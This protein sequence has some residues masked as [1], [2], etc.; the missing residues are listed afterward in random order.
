M[1]TATLASLV[2]LSSPLPTLQDPPHL[3]PDLGELHKKVSTDNPMA[4]KYFDQG[5]A[6]LYGFNMDEARKNFEYATTLDPDCAMIWWGVAQGY[7]PH[8]NAMVVPPESAMASWEAI[9]KAKSLNPTGWER[10][11]I[12]A[13]EKRFHSSYLEDRSPLDK[14]YSAEMKKVAQKYPKDPDL[15][16]LYA[17]SLMVQHPWNLHFSGGKAKPWTDDIIQVVEDTLALDEDHPLS[18]HLYIHAVEGSTTPGRATKAADTLLNLQ[19]DLGHM[20]HM[21]SHIYVRTGRWADA[22]TSNQMA[23][24]AEAEY[25][26]KSPQQAGYV[27]YMMHNHSMLAYAAM[28]S[29]RSELAMDEFQNAANYLTPEMR[30]SFGAFGDG[31]GAVQ[32]ETYVRFGL[33]DEILELPTPEDDF[34]ID[35]TIRHMARSVAWAVKGNPKKARMEQYLFYESRDNMPENWN[36][37]FYSPIDNVFRV[38]ENLMNG[39][40]LL[41]EGR[42]DE[43]I[44]RL[45]VAARA[46]DQLR[47][48]EPP[49]WLMPTRHALGAVLIKAGRHAEAEAVYR[50]DLRRTPDNGWALFGLAQA[51]QGQNKSQEANNTT[52]HFDKI[53]ALADIEIES[54]CKCVKL[55]D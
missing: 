4:Q 27:F 32:F 33:W 11:L 25:M 10:D 6:F 46:E 3:F 30:K 53:W 34:P 41:G 2:V 15:N 12:M 36:G 28:M 55:D 26:E 1:I 44:E 49:D 37:F 35:Q 50:E 38:A 48:A 45:K 21:P 47:Y 39:E 40:I 13:T 22:V 31:L 24:K 17:E 18:L 19:P 9:Q 52:E 29:G 43:S 54:S 42:I 20:V 5:L 14:A 7:G 23:I 16:A 51:L 8:L